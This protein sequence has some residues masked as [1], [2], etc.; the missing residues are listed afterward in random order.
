VGRFHSAKAACAYA[1]LVPGMLQSGAKQKDLPITKA[2]SPIL[3]WAP[4]EAA[5]RAVRHGAAWRRVY[6]GIR[7]RAGGKKAIVAVARRLLCVL[8]VML[9]DGT[10]YDFLLVG[11]HTSKQ[12]AGADGADRVGAGGREDRTDHGGGRVKTGG[13][14]W[15]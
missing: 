8:Y 5:W 14:L 6:E 15:A 9:W 12:R 4:V 1:G 13:A 3:R 11:G 10:D 2:G 7:K